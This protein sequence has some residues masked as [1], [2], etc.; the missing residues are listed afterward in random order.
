[1]SELHGL[2]SIVIIEKVVLFSIDDFCVYLIVS[3]VF[4][5]FSRSVSRQLKGCSIFPTLARS[6]AG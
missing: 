5:L 6:L 3:Y 2:S 1:M 4:I